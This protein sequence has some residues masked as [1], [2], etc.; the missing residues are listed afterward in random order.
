MA[1]ETFAAGTQEG[2]ISGHT[3]GTGAPVLLL[4]GGPAISDYT[5]MLGPELGEWRWARYQ[6]RGLPPSAVGGPF[7]VAQHVAD[8]VAV[9]DTL[10]IEQ[11]V[12]LGHSWGGHLALHLALAQPGRVAGLVIVDPLG[13]VGDGG[14][15]EM[16]QELT[17]R[18]SPAAAARLREVDARL[19]GPDPTD[20]DALASLTLVWPGY[21]A[22]PAEAPPLPPGMRMSLTAYAE[23]FA[24]AV[25]ELAAGFGEKLHAVQVPAVFVLGERSP[26][27]VS[28]GQQTA[29]LLPS[30]EVNVIPG[31]GH[32]PWHEQPGCV[33]A[34][35]AKVRAQAGLS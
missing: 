9:L 14:V 30:A 31:A 3:G 33:A 5:D 11:A 24:S 21:F 26:M 25:G 16:G 32:M 2:P 12:V 17:A 18:L 6:Q 10:G 35:L 7:T 4:H 8:A 15:T 20:D 13:A 28:Q 34:A 22:V 27:P 19:E 1:E 29:A 23:T